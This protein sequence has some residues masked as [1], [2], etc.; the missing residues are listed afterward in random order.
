MNSL[1]ILHNVEQYCKSLMES[2]RCRELP[3]HNWQHTLDVVE[4]AQ[5]IGLNENLSST[6]MEELMIAAFFHDT[7]NV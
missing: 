1:S 4:N 7:G 5:S 6:A 2:S 3:F